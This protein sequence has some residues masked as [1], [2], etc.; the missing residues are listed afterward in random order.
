MVNVA[1]KEIPR[2]GGL[3]LIG[4]SL[5]ML[6]DPLS[7]LVEQYLELGPVFKVKMGFQNYTVMAGIEANRF[8]AGDGEQYLSSERLFG[9]MAKAMKTDVMLTVLDGEPHSHMRK[10]NRRGFS[11]SQAADHIDTLV[12]IVDE[13]AGNWNSGDMIPVFEVM[14]RIVV[15]QLGVMMTGISPREYFD[16]IRTY[17]NTLMNVEALKVWPRLMLYR[18]GFLQ[19]RQRVWELGKRVLEK[20]RSETPESPTLI[21]DIL[22]GTRPDGKPFTED[23]L[24]AMSVGPYFAGMDTIASTMAFF[25]YAMAKHPDVV[26]RVKPEIEALFADGMPS[27]NDFRDA[28]VLHAAALETLRRYPVTPFTPR[29]VASDFEFEG[30][31]IEAGT[32]VM[33]GQTIL[34]FLP[35]YYEDP[36]TFNVDR[37]LDGGPG[38]IP[39]VF[40]PFTLGSHTCLGAGLAEVQMMVTMAAMLRAADYQLE[41]PDYEVTI[42]TMP[43]PNPG[44]DFRLRVRK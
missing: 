5:D 14:R 11:R 12:G 37:F 34:H 20:H 36:Y 4:N 38:R 42:H 30:H 15:D 7:Y 19:A 2:A 16:D 29:T 26:A 9:G 33:I 40:T 24:I 22:A 17:L 31:H 32:E 13:Y 25:M 39:Q 3:P 27:L 44:N 43:L 18:P 41:T 6:H 8:L 1:L 10:L 28:K 35:E 23:D 21:D